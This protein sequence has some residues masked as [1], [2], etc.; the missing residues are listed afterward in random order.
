MHVPALVTTGQLTDPRPGALGEPTTQILFGD[1]RILDDVRAGGRLQAG[2][3]F[4]D[5]Q[6]VGVEGEYLAL[7]SQTDPFRDWSDGTP[8]ISRPFF[9]VNPDPTKNGSTVEKVAFPRGQPGA[10]AGSISVDP[11][12]HFE[13]A[14][15]RLRFSLCEEGDCS[16][17][18][19]GSSHRREL[20]LGFR[21]LRLDD[22]LGIREELT[23]TDPAPSAAQGGPAGFIVQDSFATRNEFYGGEIGMLFQ[24]QNG[25]W[26][27]EFLPKVAMGNTHEIANVFGYTTTSSATSG[28]VTTAG[29]LLA[30][31]SN[32]G[33][34]A[35]DGFA[36]VPELGVT[37]A[38]QWTPRLRSTFGYSFIYWSQVARAGDQ[39]DLNV[40]STYL[41]NSPVPHA[42]PVAPVF[43]FHE[44]DFWAQGLNFGLDYRW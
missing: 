3:W 38:Y 24:S 22:G 39:I 33:T 40:N 5:C 12:T 36:V 26:S 41:P 25:R 8:I 31:P 13:S 6:T 15:A 1:S 20:I 2:L 27:W 7:G 44:S 4:S 17:D 18:P 16:A 9:D 43:A 21:Y 11:A 34:H 42:G 29:G 14:G 30:Q 10:I 28:T 32:S 35:H 19:C 23:T 37:L